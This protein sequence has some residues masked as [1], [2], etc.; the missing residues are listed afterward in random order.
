MAPQ[1]QLTLYWNR[2]GWQNRDWNL[3][4]QWERAGLLMPS[5]DVSVHSPPPLTDEVLRQI[6]PEGVSV[7]TSFEQ[8]PARL[9]PPTPPHLPKPYLETAEA[10]FGEN[11]L[12]LR[13]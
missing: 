3:V 7:P 9:L 6:L 13:V 4:N 1:P 10:W 11:V 2:Q 8:V 5:F 12:D